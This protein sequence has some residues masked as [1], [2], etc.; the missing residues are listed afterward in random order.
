MYNSKEITLFVVTHQNNQQ[1]RLSRYIGWICG[2]VDGEGCFSLGFIHQPDKQEKNRTRRGYTTRYQ[3]FHEFAVTQSE[4]S[5]KV[6]EDLQT[7]FQV[8]T[9]TCNRRYDNHTENLYRFVVRS[10]SDL[11]EVIIPFFEE[12]PLLTKKQIDFERFAQCVRLMNDGKHLT[13]AGL[14]EIAH[15]AATMNRKKL[16][17]NLERIL[18]DHTSHSSSA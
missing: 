11:L 17:K 10:R 3:V 16:G 13:Q 9:L 15:I 4:S 5:K 8:G 14:G 12:Y 1:E 6:L 18:R 2:F 7:F